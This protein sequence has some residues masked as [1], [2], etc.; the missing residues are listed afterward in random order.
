LAV[1]GKLLVVLAR[2]MDKAQKK[3]ELLTWVI[4]V[5]TAFLIEVVLR[6][7]TH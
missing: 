1:F 5:L 7:F 2:Y 6:W 3:I 4:A